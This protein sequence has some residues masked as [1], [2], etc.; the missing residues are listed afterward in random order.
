M[1]LP[2][3][4]PASPRSG[5]RYPSDDRHV[6]YGTVVLEPA[7]TELGAVVVTEKARSPKM[8]EFDERRRAGLG[9]FLDQAQIEKLNFNDMIGVIRTFKAVRVRGSGATSAREFFPCPMQVYVDG[10][11]RGPGLGELPSPREIAGVEVY[12]GPATTPLWL[13]NG[14][15]GGKKSCGVILIWTRDGS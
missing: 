15:A 3:A 13:P 9:E 1:P 8:A 6:K 4:A 12:A 7:V 2:I 11:P 14:F 5:R 10:F